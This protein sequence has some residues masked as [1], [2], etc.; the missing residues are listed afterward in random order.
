MT[1]LKTVLTAAALSAAVMVPALLA[2]TQADARVFIGVNLTPPAPQYEARPANPWGNGVWIEGHWARRDGQWVW[3]HG[4]WDRPY[5]RYS[6]WVPGHY[7][8]FGEWIPGHW[9]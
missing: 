3:I 9:R 7:N 6:A 1:K 2:S 8:R 5:G 4:H